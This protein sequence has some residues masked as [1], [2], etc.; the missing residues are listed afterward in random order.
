ML[1]KLRPFLFTPADGIH[2]SSGILLKK[3]A[4]AN[5]PLESSR[6]KITFCVYGILFYQAVYKFTDKD[7]V[8]VPSTVFSFTYFLFIHSSS[9][10]IDILRTT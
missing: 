8:I 6:T 9:D 10:D 1:E 4:K 2:V 5:P 7:S 3:I